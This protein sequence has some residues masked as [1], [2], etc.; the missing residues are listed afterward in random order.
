MTFVPYTVQYHQDGTRTVTRGESRVKLRDPNTPCIHLGE[1]VGKL[2]CDCG[3]L[4]PYYDCSQ[5]EVEYA[6]RRKIGKPAK[7]SEAGTRL[8]PTSCLS[9]Q[10]YQPSH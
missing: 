8:R 1:Q 10:L 5:P 9:C 3:G 2:D 6:I 7:D 4:I